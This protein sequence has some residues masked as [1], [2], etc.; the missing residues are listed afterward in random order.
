[1]PSHDYELMYIVRPD[2]DDEKQ[3]ATVAA[4]TNAVTTRGGTIATETNWGRKRL[5]YPIQDFRE[6]I[7]VILEFRGDASQIAPLDR[8]IRL[9]EDVIR[10]LILRPERKAPKLSRK[11]AAAA[12]AAAAAQANAAANGQ[13]PALDG[14]VAA[15]EAPP[16]ADVPAEA[17]TPEAAAT[18]A[19]EE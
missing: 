4:M 19:P 9:S 12:A 16:E 15:V 10:H 14:E 2:L 5:A 8:Q 6:G 3:A 13:V 17:P 1:M 11:A 7:Y 18:A